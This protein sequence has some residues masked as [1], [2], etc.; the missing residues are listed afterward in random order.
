MKKIVLSQLMVFC[1]LCSFASVSLAADEHRAKQLAEK[2]GFATEMASLLKSGTRGTSGEKA[3]A[4][5]NINAIDRAYAK[6]LSEH[7]S[8]S[9]VDAL[10]KAYDIPGYR[11]AMRKMP[12]VTNDLM[13]A[14][15]KEIKR[16]Q[17]KK[18][19][20]QQSNN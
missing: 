17:G 14:V 18:S 4:A 20:E 12:I 7:L 3:V 11:E 2:T 13:I 1:C 9:E 5:F 19:K 10:L 8:N 15:Q 6:S 16:F